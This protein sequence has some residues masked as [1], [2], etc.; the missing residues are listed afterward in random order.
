MLTVFSFTPNEKDCYCCIFKVLVTNVFGDFQG[1]PVLE[2]SRISINLSI[3]MS[4]AL[5]HL[6]SLSLYH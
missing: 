5:L 6:T 3:K 1:I 2:Y 4:F